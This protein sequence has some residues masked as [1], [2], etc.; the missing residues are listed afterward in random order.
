M[1]SQQVRDILIEHLDGHPVLAEKIQANA[2]FGEERDYSRRR[3]SVKL[4]ISQ[5]LLETKM[6][7]DRRFVTVITLAGRAA[8]ARALGEWADALVRAGIERFEAT[9]NPAD[10]ILEI[11]S[12]SAPKYPR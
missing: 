7:L 6:T 8:L 12:E 9:G 10:R 1:I 3:L 11:W 4:M 2:T 5:G